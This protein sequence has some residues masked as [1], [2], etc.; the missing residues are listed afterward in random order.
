MKS[1]NRSPVIM[2]G[3]LILTLIINGCEKQG[4]E[5]K[6]NKQIRLLKHDYYKVS[7]SAAFALGKIGPQTKEVVPALIQALKDDFGPRSAAATALG[8]I[9]PDAKDAVPALVEALKDENINVRR[10][11][12]GALGQIGSNA[13]EAVSALVQALKDNNDGVRRYEETWLHPKKEDGPSR[14]RRSIVEA[15]GR[16]GPEAKEAVPLIVRS[17]KDDYDP[18][19]RVAAVEAL[20]EIGSEATE[21]VPALVEALE[22]YDS[23]VGQRAAKALKKIKGKF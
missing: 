19:V 2:A 8:E 6:V 10:Y 14:L 21:A 15:L 11:A 3:M 4:V 20:G 12:A 22:D 17:L 1:Y 9:G 5:Q 16:I 23:E 13:K 18:N 7:N